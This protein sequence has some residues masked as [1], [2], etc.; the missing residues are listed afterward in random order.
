MEIF[1]EEHEVFLKSLMHRF[2]RLVANLVNNSYDAVPK[3]SNGKI[4]TYS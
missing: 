4:L 3:I 1:F 2:Q